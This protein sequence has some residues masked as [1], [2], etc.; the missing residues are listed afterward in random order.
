MK[1]FNFCYLVSV[2]I[3]ISSCATKQLLVPNKKRVQKREAYYATL[4]AYIEESYYWETAKTLNTFKAYEDYIDKYHT[5][6]FIFN[7]RKMLNPI[8]WKRACQNNTI[9]AYSEYINYLPNDEYSSEA[10]NKIENIIWVNAQTIN[11]PDAYTEYIVKYPLGKYT[12]QAKL[13]IEKPIWDN[14]NI[15]NT[16]EAYQNYL[17]NTPYGIF[18]GAAKDS[19][20]IKTWLISIKINSFQSYKDFLNAYPDSK[21]SEQACKNAWKFALIENKIEIYHTFF[22]MIYIEK[23]T[24]KNLLVRLYE[25]YNNNYLS[26]YL[27]NSL[28]FDGRIALEAIPAIIDFFPLFEDT[29]YHK[30]EEP[31]MSISGG[32]SDYTVESKFINSQY[33]PLVEKLTKG[34]KLMYGNYFSISNVYGFV[35][36][37]TERSG[38]SRFGDVKIS[39][40]IN[41]GAYALQ[42]ITGEDYGIDKVKWQQW[43]IDN[44]DSL[45]LKIL[46]Y[47]TGINIMEGVQIEQNVNILISLLQDWNPGIRWTSAM[48]L[49]EMNETSAIDPLIY[50]LKDE[51][52]NVRKYSVLALGKI[53]GTKAITAIQELFNDKNE[54]VRQAVQS[55]LQK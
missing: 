13:L 6:R 18:S 19:I 54:E 41:L 39:Y 42:L 22:S 40:K 52:N 32:I 25:N 49:G 21:Y 26:D 27:V 1:L 37:Y 53:G 14:S 35:S 29:I 31:N 45:F 10:K 51:N 16:I 47:R 50:A 28:A 4:N 15:I 3:I 55:I 46:Y 2:T 9:E 36:E 23:T 30:I 33:D 12:S 11:T 5:G 20:L 7:A 38:I 44:K 17:K 43:W 24:F 8:L 34:L 48:I